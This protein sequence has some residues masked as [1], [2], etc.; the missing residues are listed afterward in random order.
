VLQSEYHTVKTKSVVTKDETLCHIYFCIKNALKL[1][2][3]HL[4]FKKNFLG[5]LSLAIKGRDNERRKGR[6]KEREK[7][8]EKERS[9]GYSPSKFG[10]LS[11]PLTS[12]VISLNTDQ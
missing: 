10:T 7:R 9:R 8:R 11:S 6:G 1:T 4:Y 2:Y 3:D 12:Q 5:S